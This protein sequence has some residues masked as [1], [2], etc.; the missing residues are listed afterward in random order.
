[1]EGLRQ[2]NDD[3]LRS[4]TYTYMGLNVRRPDGH[5]RPLAALVTMK[6]VDKLPPYEPFNPSNPNSSDH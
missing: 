6:I 1:M 5:W 4:H 2:Y 3:H